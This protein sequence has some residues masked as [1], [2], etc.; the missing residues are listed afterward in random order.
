MSL[1]FYVCTI[2]Y[3][4]ASLVHM[5]LTILSLHNVVHVH[6]HIYIRMC[7]HAGLSDCLSVH[8]VLCVC[9]CRLVRMVV[10]LM[11]LV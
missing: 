9:P 8:S 7:I 6:V 4:I 11:Y 5:L 2:Q 3:T 10:G 1:L